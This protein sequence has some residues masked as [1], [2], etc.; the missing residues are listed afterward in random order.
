MNED[1]EEAQKQITMLLDENEFLRQQNERKTN[2]MLRT[3]ESAREV[4]AELGRSQ[5][6]TE[7][8]KAANAHFIE[9]IEKS[10][11]WV[12]KTRRWIKTLRVNCQKVLLL[13]FDKC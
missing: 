4:T 5:Q 6:E 8:L 13:V 1:L 3:L 2:L 12:N 11:R 7:S 9:K 10:E